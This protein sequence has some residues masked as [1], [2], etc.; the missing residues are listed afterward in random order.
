MQGDDPNAPNHRLWSSHFSV[1]NTFLELSPPIQESL[2]PR[3]RSASVGSRSLQPESSQQKEDSSGSSISTWEKEMLLK[4]DQILLSDSSSSFGRSSRDEAKSERNK[5]G[6]GESTTQD[7]DLSSSDEEDA[8]SLEQVRGEVCTKAR[9]RPCLYF[10][11]SA[12]CPQGSACR[13]CHLWHPQSGMARQ[14]IRPCK[15]KRERYRKLVSKIKKQI[16]SQPDLEP[17]DLDLPA[18]V[19]EN[20]SLHAKLMARITQILGE[21]RNEHVPDASE[22][23]RQDALQQAVGRL[24]AKRKSRTNI[25]SL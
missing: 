6:S 23:R 21:V 10:N 15:G 20:P 17:E 5:E 14:K 13:F 7:E 9:C 18:S 24:A 25:V 22:M 19:L 3:R 8:Q 11:S 4:L 2:P 12:G 16:E 1:K